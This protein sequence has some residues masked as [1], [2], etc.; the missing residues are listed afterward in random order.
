M[1]GKRIIA[2]Y[3]RFRDDK[4][5]KPKPLV[6]SLPN[7][8]PTQAIAELLSTVPA[9]RRLPR[10]NAHIRPRV[11][12]RDLVTELNESVAMGA[13]SQR[14][15]ILKQLQSRTEVQIKHL[16]FREDVRPGYVGTWTKRSKL[17]GPRTPFERDSS[18]LNYEVDS[19]EEWEEEPDDPD[20]EAIGD[21]EE[22]EPATDAES[23][24]DSW[25]ADDEEPLE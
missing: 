4:R 10:D 12:V 20:A 8:D 17:I 2:P 14:D 11:S 9:R 22:E 1:P 6:N 3:N 21:E 23:D 7:L 13:D 24:V 5:P 15:E 19:E 16:Q 25:L 18:T